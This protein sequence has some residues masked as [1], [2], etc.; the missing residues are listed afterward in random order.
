MQRESVLKV[1]EEQVRETTAMQSV[2]LVLKRMAAKME[3]L[4]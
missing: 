2:M 1:C 3:I 4:F